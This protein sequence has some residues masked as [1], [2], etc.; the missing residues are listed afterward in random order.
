MERKVQEAMKEVRREAEEVGDLMRRV[1]ECD[2]RNI[3]HMAKLKR[4]AEEHLKIASKQHNRL[5]EEMAKEKKERNSCKKHGTKHICRGIGEQG[6]QP[7][8]AVERDKDTP[9]GGRKG[10]VT[11]DP[12]EIDAI[13]KRAWKT[14][15]EGMK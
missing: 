8:I 14:I 10:E 4:T 7:L 5:R 6:A 12:R 3:M 1:K 15:H 11:S 13:I 2:T 9:D